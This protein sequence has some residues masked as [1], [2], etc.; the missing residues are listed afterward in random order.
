MLTAAADL[1]AKGRP[2]ARPVHSDTDR[3]ADPAAVWPSGTGRGG[4]VLGKR[5]DDP[6]RAR[7]PGLGRESPRRV[8]LPQCLYA[9]PRRLR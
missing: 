2:A 6:Q 9:S 5:G 8:P 1:R 4:A 7:L 3:R